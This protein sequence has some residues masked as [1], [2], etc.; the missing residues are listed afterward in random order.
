MRAKQILYQSQLYTYRELARVAYVK[1]D[2]EIDA[3]HIRHRMDRGWDV[4]EAIKRPVTHERGQQVT[5]WY[6]S[7]KKYNAVQVEQLAKKWK[8]GQLNQPLDQNDLIRSY[9][10]MHLTESI[11]QSKLMRIEV[12]HR[13]QVQPTN[14]Y[15]YMT[16][17]RVPNLITAVRL[18]QVLYPN[19]Q[20]EQ[21]KQFF[22][23]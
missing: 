9:F 5:Y 4:E 2:N 18:I 16:G 7:G 19:C 14:L 21:L 3:D 10:A 13:S 8:H 6:I 15:N 20:S 11:H 1:F 23:V 12:A 17:K 22:L